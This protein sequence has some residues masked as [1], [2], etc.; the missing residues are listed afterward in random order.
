MLFGILEATAMVRQGTTQNN[1]S[2][3]GNTN[4]DVDVAWCG[5]EVVL[6]S[7]TWDGSLPARPSSCSLMVMLMGMLPYLYEPCGLGL[8]ALAVRSFPVLV[9]DDEFT[10]DSGLVEVCGSHKVVVLGFLVC[11]DKYNEALANVDIKRVVVVLDGL[12]CLDGVD[13]LILAIAF[14]VFAI[15][16]DTI[17]PAKRSATV[18]LLLDSGVGLGVPVTHKNVELY[19]LECE[20]HDAE[21]LIVS[22]LLSLC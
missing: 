3:N 12:P 4:F 1:P 20:K 22:L 5:K 13:N 9:A 7:F 6:E 15:D 19:Y 21:P 11:G 14:C 16:E 8:A 18:Q 10:S 2:L 17:E